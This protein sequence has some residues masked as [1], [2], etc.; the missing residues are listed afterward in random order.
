MCDSQRQ[1]QDLHHSV[2]WVLGSILGQ[3]IFN[4]FPKKKQLKTKTL[5]ICLVEYL[6]PTR[7][8]FNV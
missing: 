7:Q 5:K 6:Y 8:I 3:Q 2:N 4:I 1:F